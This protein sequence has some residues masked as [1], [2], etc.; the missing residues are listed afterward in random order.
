M[1][2]QKVLTIAIF[3]LLGSVI[4]TTGNQAQAATQYQYQTAAPRTFQRQAAP[5]TDVTVLRETLTRLI[6]NTN[7]TDADAAQALLN[8]VNAGSSLTSQDLMKIITLC[9]AKCKNQYDR[10]GT[11][12]PSPYSSP[13][14]QTSTQRQ[15]VS[16]YPSQSTRQSQRPP[17]IQRS[18]SKYNPEAPRY[19]N[20]ATT[21][22]RYDQFR[23]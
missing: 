17:Q 20:S 18:Q 13:Y 12:K 19:P 2:K 7:A 22:S 4:S 3:A 14:S 23:N 8:K 16:K 9:N 6:T 11:Q 10:Q 1:Q 21:S 15:P 5:S